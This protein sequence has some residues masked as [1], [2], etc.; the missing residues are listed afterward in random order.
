MK[1]VLSQFMELETSKKEGLIE[2]VKGGRGSGNFGHTGRPGAIGGSGGGS[3]GST[4]GGKTRD[5]IL[6]SEL[7]LKQ[8]KK[9]TIDLAEKHFSKEDRKNIEVDTIKNNSGNACTTFVN[10]GKV[11]NSNFFMAGKKI[12]DDMK[13]IYGKRVKYHENKIHK[14]ERESFDSTF[15]IDIDFG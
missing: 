11:S 8:V 4:G 2:E 1:S 14:N 3:G 7:T 5:G 15:D 13:K 10:L 9:R 6:K 12:R